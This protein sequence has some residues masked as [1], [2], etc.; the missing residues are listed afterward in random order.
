MSWDAIGEPLNSCAFSCNM[1]SDREPVSFLFMFIQRIL[2]SHEESVNSI[3]VY[4]PVVWLGMNL[5]S[6]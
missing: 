2:D 6:S 4:F 1:S 3:I 5:G